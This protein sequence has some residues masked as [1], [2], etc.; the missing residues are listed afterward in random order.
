[1]N[2]VRFRHEGLGNSSYLIEVAPGAAIVVDADRTVG[3]YVDSAAARGW[4]IVASFDTH[5]HADFVA[6]NLELQDRAGSRPHLPKEA[7]AG[8]AHT[9][10]V[11]KERLEIGDVEIEILATPGHT[12][13]HISCVVRG[14][15]AAAPPLLCSGGALIAGGAA[16]TDLIGPG[17]TEDLTR[18]QFHTIHGAFNDLPDDTVL[19]PTH[20]AGSFCSSGSSRE[21][22]TL[23][24]ERATNPLIAETDEERFVDGWPQTFPA[25][26]AYF[27]RMRD[28]NI[29]GARL[30]REIER[31]RG[32]GPTELRDAMDSGAIVIDVR[33]SKRYASAH[34][35]G[36][37]AI[38]LRDAY[39]TWLGWVVPAE[40]T[41]LFVTDDDTSLDRALEES[42]LVGYEMFAGW[43]DGGIEAWRS[44]GLPLQRTLILEPEDVVGE[45]EA[46]ALPIDVREPDEFAL[47][48]VSGAMLAPL[49]VLD[50]RADAL[51][52]DRRIVTYCASGLRSTT[53]ASI[54][55]RHGFV[56]VAGIRGG[57]GAWREA[58]RD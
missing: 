23:G 37:L 22:T 27:A 3:R 25:V 41:L 14:S 44:A 54:L 40:A 49:G 17:L 15:D 7:G 50:A 48:A 35:P 28:V 36:S 29:T 34:V 43:L 45:L 53:A 56:D 24:V 55:E 31:P 8:F 10:V 12:P 16:R 42:M 47:G 11:P 18:A 46:G 4:D 19:L 20:G 21:A 26:P 57:Y 6:G 51:P 38:E 13:E 1:M 33:S 58:G 32:L 2:I 30:I 9:G 52:R 39:C 5:L